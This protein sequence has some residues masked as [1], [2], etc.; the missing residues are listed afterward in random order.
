MH[1]HDNQHPW[2][3]LDAHADLARAAW[4]I[5]LGSWCTCA[6]SGNPESLAQGLIWVGR[7]DVPGTVMVVGEVGD[8]EGFDFYRYHLSILDHL[9]RGSRL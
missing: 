7:S 1:G 5:A 6:S 9:S 4:P 2:G 3:V 8:L